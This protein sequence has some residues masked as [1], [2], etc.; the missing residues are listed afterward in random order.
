MLLQDPAGKPANGAGEACPGCH[1]QV[2]GCAGC[3]SYHAEPRGSCV[4][5]GL[6]TAAATQHSE[7]ALTPSD[8]VSGHT[9]ATGCKLKQLPGYSHS[10]A[11]PDAVH[12]CLSQCQLLAGLHPAHLSSRYRT[13]RRGQRAGAS[14]HVRGGRAQAH[15]GTL[16][17]LPLCPNCL[18]HSGLG[19]PGCLGGRCCHRILGHGKCRCAASVSGWCVAVKRAPGGDCLAQA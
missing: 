13:G 11:A 6:L 2:Q 18:L 12:M 16:S 15:G 5:A 19:P 10:K 8:P 3:Q 7:A 9:L 1:C 14:S 4:L 17:S